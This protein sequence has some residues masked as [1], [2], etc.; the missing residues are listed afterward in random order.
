MQSALRGAILTRESM[1]GSLAQLDRQTLTEFSWSDI[2]KAEIPQRGC[3]IGQW[4]ARTGDPFPDLMVV[5]TEDRNDTLAWLSAYFAAITPL[6]QWCRF[7]SLDQVEAI[8]SAERHVSLGAWLSPWVGAIMAECSVQ[9]DGSVNLKELPGS[10]AL[11]T[12]S[13]AAGRAAALWGTAAPLN[14]LAQRHDE[15]SSRMRE[16]SRRISAAALAPLWNVL[17]NALEPAPLGARSRDL[18]PFKH[19]VASALRMGASEVSEVLNAVSIEA[20]DHFDLPELADCARGSQS[21]R[22]R[23]L[24]RLAERLARGPVAPGSDALLGLGASFVDPGAAVMPDL[25]RRYSNRHPLSPVWLGAFA[26]AWVPSRVLNDQQGL[27][28]IIAKAL[29]ANSDLET[30]PTADISFDEL[31]RWLGPGRTGHR[32]EVRGMAARTISVELLPGVSASFAQSRG[33]A[34]AVQTSTRRESLRDERATAPTSRTRG[35]LRLEDVWEGLMTLTQRVDRLERAAPQ[36]Q[37]TLDL[38]DPPPTKG[39]RTPTSK[40]R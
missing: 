36:T 30:K 38:R 8:A 14:D 17:A 40:G 39:K 18:E 16:G 1:P 23:A 32:V 33:E 35:D 5:R 9:S 7:L 4:G 28:R 11:S 2:A 37:N 26:G 6:T 27:G 24:D 13:Y 21:D 29:L 19:I 3:L 12:A 22:V 34:A 25:L 10:A 15:L 31:I 20:T